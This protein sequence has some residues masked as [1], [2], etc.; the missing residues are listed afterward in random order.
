MTNYFY[1]L[2]MPRSRTLWLSFLLSDNE[3]DCK[4]EGL[5][6]LSCNK[7]ADSGKKY[8]GSVDTNP[9]NN[10]IYNGPLIVIKRN[11]E[12]VK[13]SLNKSFYI[14]GM[15]PSEKEKFISD[16]AKKY[17]EA[18]NNKDSLVFEY[19]DLDDPKKVLSM[20]KYLKPESKIT[21]E[22]IIKLQNCVITT[23]NNDLTSSVAF[24]A[25]EV[26]AE[27]TLDIQLCADVLLRPDIFATISEDGATFNSID[28]D[29]MDNYWLKLTA[30]G[31]LIG[32]FRLKQLFNKC[33]EGH[34]H[35]LPEYR[36]KFSQ[37]CG[38][39]IIKWSQENI[40]GSTIL[41]TVPAMYRNVVN[42]LNGF[43][44]KENGLMPK[45]FL[46]NNKLHDLIILTR[47]I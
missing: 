4:H 2:A 46:K 17:A 41:T 1:V 26:K 23:K 7:L 42:F 32:I 35:I 40:K 15:D 28:F 38:E 10:V 29:V 16:H 20:V 45:C 3:S 24:L 21:L 5:S 9:L 30:N 44:F 25:N 8:T 37:K 19:D 27:R 43:E 36:E 31:A 47:F 6:D 12:D 39:Q 18:L 34:I 13:R 33:Y 14:S 11:I 22:E